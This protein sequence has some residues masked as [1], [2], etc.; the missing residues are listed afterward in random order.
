MLTFNFLNLFFP[1]L[2]SVFHE[3][4]H[5]YKSTL[6]QAASVGRMILPK[7]P[8]DS[9]SESSIVENLVTNLLA[10]PGVKCSN[11]IQT[12]AAGATGSPEHNT[13]A[14]RT[15]RDVSPTPHSLHSP[16]V[17][18]PAASTSFVNV[19]EFL[20]AEERVHPENL[21]PKSSIYANMVPLSRSTPTRSSPNSTLPFQSPLL[22]VRNEAASSLPHCVNDETSPP[23][24]QKLE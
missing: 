23:K 21:T 7:Q 9:S 24:K 1:P 12:P 6:E 4:I 18:T 10:N 14:L 17:S 3:F 5:R 16:K 13:S 20:S 19:E 11:S 22:F 8:S 2:A 15:E